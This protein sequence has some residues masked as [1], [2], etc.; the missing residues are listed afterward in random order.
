MNN[1]DLVAV[2]YPVES[3]ISIN[4]RG[5]HCAGI[6]RTASTW[7]KAIAA[8]RVYIQGIDATIELSDQFDRWNE[9]IR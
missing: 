6:A 1:T 2:W 7:P 9:T 8:C 3:L 4:R 5:E